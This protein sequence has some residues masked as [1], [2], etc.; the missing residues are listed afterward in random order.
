MDGVKEILGGRNMRL[1]EGSR[2]AEDR[3]RWREVVRVD[4]R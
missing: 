2:L 1:E 4:E 3:V